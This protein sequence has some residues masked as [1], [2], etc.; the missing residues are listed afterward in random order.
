MPVLC[1]DCQRQTKSKL[2][3]ETR[4]TDFFYLCLA[5]FY[6]KNK[7]KKTESMF[8]YSCII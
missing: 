8:F 5:S 2:E 1:Y 7:H 3:D 6:D 4:K